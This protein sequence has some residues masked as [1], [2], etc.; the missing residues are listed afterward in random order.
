VL[1]VDRVVVVRHSRPAFFGLG[2][3]TYALE[4]VVD[5]LTY[6]LVPGWYTFT[7]FSIPFNLLAD[8]IGLVVITVVFVVYARA[9]FNVNWITVGWAVAFI[10]GLVGFLVFGLPTFR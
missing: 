9:G 3:L 5:K 7:I 8:L 10:L 6:A 4:Y 2:V 1:R